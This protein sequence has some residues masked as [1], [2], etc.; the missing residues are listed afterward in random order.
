MSVCGIQTDLPAGHQ[1]E[2]YPAGGAYPTA[3]IPIKSG[4]VIKL[5]TEYENDTG[6]PQTD[7]MGIMMAWYAPTPGGYPRP[8]GASPTR[9]AL[10]PAYNACTSPNRTHGA[11]L[12]N[13]SCN[14]PVQS[15]SFLTMG[16]PDA[17]G[18]GANGTGSLSMIVVP[19]NSSTTADEADVKLK[20]SAL[21][22]RKTDL[23]DYTGQLKATAA[24]RIT[25]RDNGPAELG[26]GD[27]TYSFTVPC[28]STVSTTIGSTCSIDTT[29]DAL[30]ANTIKE[31]TR[32]VW[33][34]GK[35][36]VLDGGADGVASTDPNTRFLTQGYF[37]P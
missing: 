4:D 14:P 27:T 5:H 36:D 32:A 33:Q 15:S 1:P 19:G 16:S 10:V 28:A 3:G 13:G 34:L 8:K 37:V 30:V 23:S 20:L 18:A 24:V 21:D 26:T 17:N 11:P 25:D 6:S 12:S 35:V 7:V 22:V 31:G 2:A 9:L 29:S